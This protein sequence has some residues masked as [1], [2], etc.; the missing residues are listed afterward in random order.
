[1]GAGV[2][3]CMENAREKYGASDSKTLI[4][5]IWNRCRN[6]QK[7]KKKVFALQGNQHIVRALF[8]HQPAA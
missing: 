7:L 6:G 5:E 4:V 8:G 1:M 3:Y 2:K